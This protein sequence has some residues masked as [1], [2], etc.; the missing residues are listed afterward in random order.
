MK[1]INKLPQ[2]LIPLSPPFITTDEEKA[3]QKVLRS[4]ILGL[5]KY[6]EAFEKS[7]ADFVGTKYAIAVSSGT[8]GLHASVVTLGLKP[9]DEVITS[10]FSFVS[11]ANA[12]LY[13]Q[14]KPVFVDIDPE[15]LNINPENIESAITKSTK[16]ILPVHIFGYPI[17]YAKIKKLAEKYKLKI[18][19]DA[20]ESLGATY[21]GKK[22]GNFGN[23]AVFAFYPNKQITT[24]EG[25]MI[26]TNN[27]E[28]YTLLKSLINQGRGD[29]G[30]WLSHDKLGFNYRMD[31]MSAAVGLMQMKKIKYILSSRK[32]AALYYKR[33]LKKNNLIKTLRDDDTVYS[34]SWQAFIVLLDKSIDRNKTMAILKKNKIQ[35]KPYLPSIHLQP[36]WKKINA[37][38]GRFPVSESTSA[39][40]LALPLYTDMKQSDIEKVC[41][42]LEKAVERARR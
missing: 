9:G 38:A 28:D 40:S 7:I 25:G 35:S 36:Y 31:E 27:K 30:Q 39:S 21:K 23:L 34:R 19:E 15:T 2:E 18:V 5:G 12:I 33:I 26:V 3:V 4:G 24:G 10:P 22:V 17:N 13:C 37:S 29:S 11:S 42:S 8:A 41:L 16:A 6:L 20:C 32:K 14:A 1:R